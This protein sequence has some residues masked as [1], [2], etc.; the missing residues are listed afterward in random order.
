MIRAPSQAYEVAVYATISQAIA[1]H[2]VTGLI[3][4]SGGGL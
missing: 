1:R 2:R 3:L 4:V